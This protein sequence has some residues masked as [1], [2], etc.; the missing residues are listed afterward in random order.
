[1][2]GY[3][4]KIL[5]KFVLVFILILSLSACGGGGDSAPQQNPPAD[6]P[7]SQP[8]DDPVSL[9]ITGAGVEGPL[10]NA[11]VTVFSFDASRPDFR[12]PVVATATTDASTAI[13]GLNLPL[14][15]SPP[16]IME[17]TSVPGT[18]DITT[19][20]FPV[21]TTMR[22]VIT[23]SQLD[24]GK[25]IYATP[26]TTI[27]VDIAVKNVV[28]NNGTAGIQADEFEAA[29]ALA[30][31][32]VMSTLGFGIDSSIA[33]S[34]T[35]PLINDDTVSVAEQSKVAGYRSAVE[36]VTA[37]VYQISQQIAG[38]SADEVLADL[39]ADLADDDTINGSSGSTLNASTL[40][41]LQQDPSALPIPDTSPVQ[42]V[43]DV[44]S[45]LAAETAITGFAT[46]TTALTDGTIVTRLIPAIASA[47][48]DGD[49]VLNVDD[50][51][52]FNKDESID[53]D[54][55]G[56]GDNADPDDD[57][58]GILD[59]DE[60]I[61][62]TPAV[63]DTDGDG[64]KNNVD[65]C[66]NVF[67]PGQTDK[68]G[69]TVGDACDPDDDGDG[70]GDNLDA[71]PVDPNRSVDTDSDGIDDATDT[72]D[73]NDGIS[74]VDDD[75]LGLDG[76]TSCSL[77]VDC[78]GDGVLDGVDADRTDPNIGIYFAISINPIA[79]ILINE[80]SAYTSVTPA[81][82]GTPIGAVSYSLGGVDAADFSID[83]A[84]GVVSMVA[85]DFEAPVDANTDN[86]Y[87]LTITV[88][89]TDGNSD[90]EAWSVTI[91]D[92]A[93][94]SAFTVDA[95]NNVSINEN[96][97]YTS[98]TPAITGTPIGVV[99]YS[100]GGAD[101]SL[102]T[103]DSATGVASM[104]ARD[105]E[106]PADA[107]G[108]NVYAL[109]IT[110]TDSDNNTASQTWTV[111]VL[112]TVEVSPI[113]ITPISDA[114]VNENSA[115]TS[116]TPAITGAPIG[117]VSYSLGGMDAA[118][119]SI[120]PATGVVSMVARD[121][122]APVDANADNIYSL[123]ITVM[124]TDGNSDSEAWSVTVVNVAEVS[125]I[126]ITPI[127]DASVNENSAYTSV[128]PAI[129]GAPIGVVSYSLG[130]TDAADFSIDPATGVVSMVARDFEAPVDANA[131]NMYQLNITV[132]DTDGNSDSEAWSVT[133]AD[134]TETA[135]FSINTIDNVSVNENSAY[136]SVTPAIT[137]TPIG[138]VSYSLGGTD[139]ADFSINPATGVV[140]MVARDYEAPVDANTDNIY[141]LSITVTDA[142][143]NSDSEPWSVTVTDVTEA[144]TF[145]I[146]T[147]DNVSIN[148]NSAYTSVTPAITGAPIGAVSYS[149]G[150]ID[151]ADF[152][153]DPATGVVSM[154]ARDY[155]APVD[156]NTDNIYQLNIT[157]T[158]ADGNSDSEPWSVTVTDVT[159]VS[160]FTI[161]AINNVSINE[162]SAYTSVIPAIT[163]TPIGVV[164]YSLGGADAASFTIDINTGVVS[165]V[166]RDFESPVD[167]DGNNVYALTITVTD[168]N[169]NTASQSWTVSIQDV[170]EVSPISIT[171]ISDASVNENSA[172]TS[173]TPA[174]T[175][176]PI[177]AVSYSLGGT[178]AADFS[179]D[180]VTGV[181]SM[182]ARDYETPVDANTDNIYQLS[183]T[184]T[185][186]DGNS[187]SEA[188]NVTVADVTET[189][190]FSINA[191]NNVSINENSVYTSV[192][193]AIT[194]MPIG[195]VSY[196]LGGADA[197]LFTIDSATGVVS[198]I[199]R[200]FES[201]ADAGANNV[202]DLSITATD[203]DGNSDSEAWS[204]TVADLTETATFSINAI[205]N[206]SINENSVYTSVS[207]A[208]TGTPIGV[209][210]YSLGGADASLFTIDSAT[211][212]VS[213]VV[214]DFESPAD[215]GANNVYDLSITATDAD[216]NN[217]SEAWSVTVTDVT[218]SATF[219]INA[220]NN[221]SISENSAYTSVTPAIT[222]M[223]IG[224]VS[225]SL[226]GADASLFTIDSA[227]GVVSMVVRD[228]ENPADADG[229]NVYALTITATD[230]N[231]NTASQSWTVSIQ[232]VVEVSPISITPISD[233][234]VNENSAYTS[235][236]PVIT[237]TPIGAVS[238]S[239]GGADS[240]DFSIDPATGVVSMVARDYEAPVDAN[241]DNIYQLSITVTDAD[242]NSDSEAWNVTVVNVA[243]VSPISIAPISD[244]SVNENSVYTSVTPAITGAPIG[245]VSY[246]LGGTDAADFSIDT[247][248]GVVSMVARDFEFQYRFRH[249]CGQH[250]RTR[251]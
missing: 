130:G 56:V 58:D 220:I 171:L 135:T 167:V 213:M 182:I 190:T 59:V 196:S 127:S 11:V 124:D 221:V 19:G 143:G 195:V 200:D 51:L 73:D 85:R 191:I 136:V 10:A 247:V 102:F 152:S 199:V 125:P 245:V 146:D 192:S 33:A 17:F 32:K 170:V 176:T 44:Q 157:A 128:T 131:D 162:N 26:L 169:S 197:S 226:G 142:D 14:P 154:V 89:D 21:V 238:Y 140:S 13:T 223:P 20:K 193:P 144:S 35:P 96:S 234:S 189:A 248:T 74:D 105:F 111:S 41:V 92:V 67:N 237:G 137:G 225:Y 172:Y 34:N 2:N 106:N 114:S 39:A 194:G 145:T 138:A 63:N 118:D 203:A 86:I 8:P 48:A 52:P 241:T 149:L 9:N 76:S 159:E 77:L 132:M 28:D 141:Q 151:A 231:S 178:D 5:N 37:I 224:A 18:T 112:D 174:I 55:D 184:V 90:S 40:Q 75:G 57:N 177:G 235:V 250:G 91:T 249:G 204:V 212:V 229:N 94:A 45:I 129:T 232:D 108:N 47:D 31:S 173:V 83:P 22:T 236:T 139:A 69:D 150:G 166:V 206:V 84:T 187:D 222:G 186:T 188:W 164:S 95:I 158:D 15:L 246:S 202:Y 80:N 1:M 227:T 133:V 198:M 107:D 6:D 88:T 65:N 155:E 97:A 215:A 181:V 179:I 99:S 244:A 119:F 103:I 201:P 64:I 208:I 134:V 120:D 104:V 46:S 7:I 243:E 147:I 126:S 36:A 53:S 211:G 117:V 148:E 251:L 81:I 210:S 156:A 110:A 216:G 29:L 230:S 27:A 42:T 242:G 228:F 160:T 30:V 121:F 66:K 168:S 50:D 239:L 68:D 54:G 70:I 153:I 49:G 78:D 165:M 87:D 183:I 209:V 82:T 185:D 71:F 60:G 113:S 12:G 43:A 122:E 175:G 116:V 93:E 100:L 207:P 3:S 25:A 4:E 109:T 101:A 240:A 180:T 218:E 72:D 161:N 217:D 23:Q 233:V 62:S 61:V 115:Y 79:N 123:S 214:R 205:N 16:Y 24:T 98:V 38:A 219:S 163:G